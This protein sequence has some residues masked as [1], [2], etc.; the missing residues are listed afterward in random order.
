MISDMW[1]NLPAEE[2]ARRTADARAKTDAYK[3]AK[4]AHEAVSSIQRP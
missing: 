1:K 2:K 4:A 3:A